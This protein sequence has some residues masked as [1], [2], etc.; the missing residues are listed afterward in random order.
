[1]DSS[2]ALL[3][4]L[5]AIFMGGVAH[6]VA[7]R[8]PGPRR[9]GL[10]AAAAAV[11]TAASFLLMIYLAGLA[12]P[13]T[14]ALLAVLS[15]AVTYLAFRRDLGPKRAALAATGAAVFVTAC[16]LF[17]LYLAVIAFVAAIGVYLL[18]RDR[19]RIKGALI[20]AGTTLSGLLAA[21]VLAFWFSL[22]Y[23][24]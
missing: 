10:V 11:A 19:L 22:T 9:A 3:I 1:M 23:V 24:M 7:R 6:R 13:A 17:V 20:L 2:L 5:T 8:D 4:G 16:F 15:G 21:A 18:V 12:L 14:M